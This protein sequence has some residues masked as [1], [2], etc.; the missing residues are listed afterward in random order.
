MRIDLKLTHTRARAE[1]VTVVFK[2]SGQRG[3]PSV[4][5]VGRQT[6]FSGACLMRQEF[7][8]HSMRCLNASRGML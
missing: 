2:V 6:I 8:K 7:V 1:N 4:L 5:V 3:S